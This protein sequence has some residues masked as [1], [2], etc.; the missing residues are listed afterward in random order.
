MKSKKV[1]ARVEHGKETTQKLINTARQVFSKCGYGRA[2]TEEIVNL[3]GV[4]RGALYHHF[5]NKKGLFEAVLDDAQKDIAS[6]IMHAVERES[7]LWDQFVAG[8]R[9]FLESC[10]DPS[11]QQIVVIDGP[12]VV[13]W[14]I[15]RRIDSVHGLNLLKDGLRELVKA[16]IIK[17]LPIDPIAH[18]LSG[19]MNE[20]ALWIA[21]SK[22][23]KKALS[24]VMNSLEIL[25]KSLKV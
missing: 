19:A 11:L 6:R 18:L 23:P 4:T 20:A 1:N 15:W 25:L 17:P 2:S 22:E 12:A 24:E 7:N 3:A 5:E 21:Q 8:C 10:I 16:G 13:G 14:E 9:A